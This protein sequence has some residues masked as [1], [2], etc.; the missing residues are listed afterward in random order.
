MELAPSYHGLNGLIRMET[1]FAI[2]N[3]NQIKR[4]M[5]MFTDNP[6]SYTCKVITMPDPAWNGV[7]IPYGRHLS[8]WEV[9]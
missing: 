6:G 8:P 3:V 7:I 1:F 9:K 2:Q 5:A 4:Q